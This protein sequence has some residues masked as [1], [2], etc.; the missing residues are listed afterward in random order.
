MAESLSLGLLLFTEGLC[1]LAS[2]VL[3]CFLCDPYECLHPS[4]HEPTGN[5]GPALPVLSSYC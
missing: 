2:P 1:S 3:V 5:S 4:T